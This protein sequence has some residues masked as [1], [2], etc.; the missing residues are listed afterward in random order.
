MTA[1]ASWVGVRIFAAVFKS[2]AMNG[3]GIGVISAGIWESA[4]LPLTASWIGLITSLV[5]A[6]FLRPFAG[7]DTIAAEGSRPAAFGLLMT[8]GLTIGLAPLLA[9]RP[10]ITFVL[11][12]ITPGTAIPAAKIMEHFLAYEVISACCFVAAAQHGNHDHSGRFQPHDADVDL[13]VQGE[14]RN[15]QFRPCGEN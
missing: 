1:L 15:D 11:R 7:N 14:G 2:V 8:A 6:M 3:G 5:A 9:F 10:A 4:Q 12:A 13:P